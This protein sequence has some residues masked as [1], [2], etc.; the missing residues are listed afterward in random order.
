[1][2]EG[3]RKAREDLGELGAQQRGGDVGSDNVEQVDSGVG[4]VFV[5]DA[6]LADLATEQRQQ[7]GKVCCRCG[8]RL[9]L[10]ERVFN[11]RE[12][13]MYLRS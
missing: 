8:F 3:R 11:G 1:V 7:R 2:C 10:A 9:L 6:L 13:D 5:R 12:Q 4:G